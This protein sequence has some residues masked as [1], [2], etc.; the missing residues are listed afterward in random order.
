MVTTTS[1]LWTYPLM[2]PIIVRHVLALPRALSNLFGAV[3]GRNWYIS[4]NI[5]IVTSNSSKP[6][7]GKITFYHAPAWA[8]TTRSA[9]PGPVDGDWNFT[10][11][12]TRSLRIE[13]DVVSGDSELNHVVWTQNLQFSNLQSYLDS[14]THQVCIQMSL[15]GCN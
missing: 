6:T 3:V 5:Q 7:T 10:T 12:A 14:A 8:S 13:A 1:L 15:V 11:T 9:T 2:S 4:G